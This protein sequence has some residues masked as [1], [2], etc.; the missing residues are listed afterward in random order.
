MN[1]S[2]AAGCAMLIAVLLLQ[3]GCAGIRQKQDEAGPQTGQ[4]RAQTELQARSVDWSAASLRSGLSRLHVAARTDSVLRVRAAVR[5]WNSRS[6]QKALLAPI[7]AL[8]GSIVPQRRK[9]VKLA[10]MPDD[11]GR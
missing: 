10:P 6:G 3:E 1:R 2:R 11:I 4:V 7:R 8:S 9:P 5:N